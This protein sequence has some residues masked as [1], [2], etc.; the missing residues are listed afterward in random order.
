MTKK[1]LLNKENNLIIAANFSEISSINQEL[2][3]PQS[4]IRDAS[5]L[6]LRNHA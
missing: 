2:S 5:F 6:L 3:T 4:S 1:I